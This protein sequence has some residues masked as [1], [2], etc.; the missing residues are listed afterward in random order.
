VGGEAV[1]EE[2]STQMSDRVVNRLVADRWSP[3]IVKK[4]WAPIAHSF[5]DLYTKLKTPL[6]TTEAMV[7]I[8]LMRFKWDDRHPFPSLK[9]LGRMMGLGSTSI[10]NYIRSLEEKGYLNRI[11]RSGFSN[12]FDLR[13]LFEALEVAIKVEEMEK[14]QVNKQSVA[15]TV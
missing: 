9:R 7:V 2:K 5:L 4:G 15:Q 14:V 1:P 13:P 10:R 8:Q 12:A 3:E 11:Y 6:T